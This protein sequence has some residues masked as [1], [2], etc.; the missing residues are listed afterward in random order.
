MKKILLKVHKSNQLHEVLTENFYLN[1]HDG[2]YA[3]IA[4]EYDAWFVTTN[5]NLGEVNAL[6]SLSDDT[7]EIMFHDEVSRENFETWLIEANA[8][9]RD[10]YRNMAG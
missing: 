10:G 7:I 9:A 4:P 6:I 1:M 5:Y 2:C 3:V 8:K